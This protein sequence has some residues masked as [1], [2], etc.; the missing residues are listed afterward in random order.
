MSATSQE[1]SKISHKITS[2][3]FSHELTQVQQNQTASPGGFTAPLSSSPSASD[4]TETVK[5]MGTGLVVV[6]QPVIPNESTGQ[7]EAVTETGCACRGKEIGKSGQAKA[8]AL[9]EQKAQEGLYITDL[10]ALERIMAQLKLS[11]EA[12]QTC[13]SSS[14]KQGRIPIKAFRS[15]LLSQSAHGA[16]KVA[17]QDVA[18]LIESLRRVQ[19][20]NASTIQMLNVKPTGTYSLAELS[21]LLK[22]IVQDAADHQRKTAPLVEQKS[23]T[24]PVPDLKAASTDIEPALIPGG[25][26]ERLAS[27]RIPTF[28]KALRSPSEEIGS[29]EADETNISV[30]LASAEARSE[31]ATVQEGVSPAVKVVGEATRGQLPA[32]ESTRLVQD[33]TM[34]FSS[35]DIDSVAQPAAIETRNNQGTD[36]ATHTVLPE[37]KVLD[38]HFVSEQPE[39]GVQAGSHPETTVSALRAGLGDEH[40][41]QV[42]LGPEALALQ[43]VQERVSAPERGNMSSGGSH[44]GGSG[45]S[46]RS[47]DSFHSTLTRIEEQAR[48]ADGTDPRQVGFDK[49]LAEGAAVSRGEQTAA[50]GTQETDAPLMLSESS[51]PDALSKQIEETHRRGRSQMTIELEPASLGKL[52]LRIEADR[53]HVTAWVSTQSEEAKGLLLNGASSL[54]QHLEEHGLTLGQFSVDVGQG[55]ERRFAQA[56]SSSRQGAGSSRVERAQRLGTNIGLPPRVELTPDRLISVFA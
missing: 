28:S 22:N 14:D 27:Q 31:A 49:A 9:S 1:R 17:A 2:R 4:P 50:A 39:V 24:V 45:E 52:V 5:P 34:A 13:Q 10:V 41:G 20:G 3:E 48:A 46:D 16:D 47:K 18:E 33:E 19:N 8:K 21:D 54:R 51:W 6:P 37:M 11:A 25:Q 42:E 44:A 36:W 53:N 29:S 40:P 55:G 26:L 56:G 23:N 38:H 43:D 7:T 30:A 35:V 15:M 32:V 12:R